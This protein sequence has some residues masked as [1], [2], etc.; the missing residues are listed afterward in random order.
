MSQRRFSARRA[1][2]VAVEGESDRVFVQFLGELCRDA[3]LH[4]HLDIHVADGGDSLG[5]VEAAQRGHRRHAGTRTLASR[6]VL[7]DSDR[8]AA[9]V[10]AGRDAQATAEKHGI[11]LIWMTPNLEGLLLRL[12]PGC[13]NRWP[14]AKRATT[15]LRKQWPKYRKPP[16]RTALVKRFGIEDV[17]RASKYDDELARLLR[18]LK[19]GG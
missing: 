16:S 14:I 9:D 5:V 1:I 19:L 4:V 18:V 17:R 8:R 15:E 11:E 13:E 6:V 2:L 7:A 3:R 10:S 12:H